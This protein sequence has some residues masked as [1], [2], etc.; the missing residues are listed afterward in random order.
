MSKKKTN[1]L[2]ATVTV[3]RQVGNDEWRDHHISRIFYD[4]CRLEDIKSFA[5]AILGKDYA[6]I[7][8]IKLSDYDESD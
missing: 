8:D 7:G 3:C 4:D 1:A 6:G 5:K 2:V